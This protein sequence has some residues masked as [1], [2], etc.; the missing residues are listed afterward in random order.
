MYDGT[1]YSQNESANEAYYILQGTKTW[2]PYNYPSTGWYK[3]GVKSITVTHSGDGTG[4][5]TLSGEWDCG[6]DSA[7]TPRHLTVSGS[8]TLPTEHL[9]CLPQMA[10]WAVM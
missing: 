8:V 4:K 10:Q 9:P 6:F 2:N 7:Y 5:V 3:L 1:G